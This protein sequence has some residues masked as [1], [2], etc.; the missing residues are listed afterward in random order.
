MF[1]KL[2]HQTNGKLVSQN[3]NPGTKMGLNFFIIAYF[4]ATETF[5]NAINLYWRRNFHLNYESLFMNNSFDARK[6]KPLLRALTKVDWYLQL[7]L[8]RDKRQINTVSK[9]H[10]KIMIFAWESLSEHWKTS[11]ETITNWM[12]M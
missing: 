7:F 11:M 3:A 2:T 6:L 4:Y 5:L 1:T 8:E 9:T 10:N 12:K